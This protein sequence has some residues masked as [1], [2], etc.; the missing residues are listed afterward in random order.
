[1]TSSVS[2]TLDTFHFG[3]IRRLAEGSLCP[4]VQ[5]IYEFAWYL[6][7]HAGC[8]QLLSFPSYAWNDLHEDLLHN[9]PKNWGKTVCLL[10]AW[11]LF[12]TCFKKCFFSYR[13]PKEAVLL[14][15]IYSLWRHLVR[16]I[17][18]DC[19]NN[20]VCLLQHIN[21]LFPWENGALMGHSISMSPGMSMLPI[22]HESFLNTTSRLLCLHA[23]I[24][25]GVGTGWV[26]ELFM[27]T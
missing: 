9:F 20:Q 25:P 4:I 26:L 11:I 6:L 24:C 12:L 21:I 19:V 15:D 5:V 10:V 23:S 1:M 17:T 18:Y 2:G 16:G 3:V 14:E 22:N 27:R 13:R 8:L 7:I